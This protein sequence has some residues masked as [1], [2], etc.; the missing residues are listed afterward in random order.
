MAR[1]KY[2][3][4]NPYGIK[5]N[6]C[7]TRAIS[8][9]LNEDY[10]YI[11]FLLYQN[12]EKYGCDRL[13]KVCYRQVLEDKFGLKP[14][15]GHGRTV[16]EIADIYPY[17]KVIMRVSGHMTMS[18]SGIVFDIFPPLDMVVDEYWVVDN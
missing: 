7:V 16:E 9:A 17:D 1:F 14:Q 3:N 2:W 8:F 18:D 15:R 11:G 12:A 4:V 6:D 13:T 10:H 5:E